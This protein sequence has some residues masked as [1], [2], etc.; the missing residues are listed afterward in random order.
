M[1]FDLENTGFTLEIRRKVHLK[2]TR[3]R[4]DLTLALSIVDSTL[5]HGRKIRPGL[6]DFGI[7][8]KRQVLSHGVRTATPCNV[9]T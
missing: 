7:P 1:S 3:P 4:P 8:R 5:F 2:A 6:G 9:R